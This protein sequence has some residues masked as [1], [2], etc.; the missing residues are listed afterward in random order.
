MKLAGFKA[1]RTD[2]GVRFER[3]VA[4]KGERSME[5]D[6]AKQLR[7]IGDTVLAVQAGDLDAVPEVHKVDCDCP[8]CGDWVTF[9]GFLDGFPTSI[10]GRTESVKACPFREGC[11]PNGVVGAGD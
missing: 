6:L 10:C 3:S 5:P 9:Q 2:R 7:Q 1:Y 11:G 8:A 4:V